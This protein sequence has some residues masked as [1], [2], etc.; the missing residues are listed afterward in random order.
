VWVEYYPTGEMTGDF[1]TKPLQ[2][3][4]FRRFQDRVLNVNEDVLKEQQKMLNLAD[5]WWYKASAHHR[6]VLNTNGNQE[7]WRTDKVDDNHKSEQK[8][9]V[10]SWCNDDRSHHNSFKYLVCLRIQPCRLL[11]KYY[12]H[13]LIGTAGLR[14]TVVSTCIRS[15]L[16]AQRTCNSEG[17]YIINVKDF[18]KVI[19][20]TQRSRRASWR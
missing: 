9:M 11:P 15:G 10:G 13:C 20:A 2:G 16:L 8:V 1:F 6:S 18:V 14:S 12:Y 17:L 5:E 7:G 19:P 3:A 4:A